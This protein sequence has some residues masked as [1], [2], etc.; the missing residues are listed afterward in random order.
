M[1]WNSTWRSLLLMVQDAES[2]WAELAAQ[3]PLSLHP[4]Q[5][6]EIRQNLRKQTHT[7]IHPYARTP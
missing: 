6:P 7:Y 2:D 3:T 5:S 1:I 4:A